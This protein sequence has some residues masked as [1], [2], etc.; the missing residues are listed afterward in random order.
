MGEQYNLCAPPPGADLLMASGGVVVALLA[1]VCGAAAAVCGALADRY[2]AA[3]W[4]VR[5]ALVVVLLGVSDVENVVLAQLHV[6]YGLCL[7]TRSCHLQCNAA[8]TTLYINSL[9]QLSSLHATVLSLTANILTTVQCC[10]L[11]FWNRSSQPTVV[12]SFNCSLC[13][14]P[15]GGVGALTLQETMS[16]SWLLGACCIVA[17]AALVSRSAAAQTQIDAA[18][19]AAAVA[20]AAA[21]V[22]LSRAS[23]SGKLD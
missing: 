22:N 12:R 14:C 23:K 8:G 16:G 11:F 5:P 17:G 15:Q 10:L 6:V 20:A 1:G 4:L 2:S 3:S 18:R 13:A 7:C 21:A 19:P 9:Q